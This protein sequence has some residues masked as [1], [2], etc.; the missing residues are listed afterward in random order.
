MQVCASCC[1]SG[2]RRNSM[3]VNLLS[4]GDQSRQSSK[5]SLSA[6]QIAELLTKFSLF[7][8]K[9]KISL[10]IHRVVQEFIRNSLTVEETEAALELAITLFEKY[11]NVDL[12]RSYKCHLAFSMAYKHTQELNSHLLALEASEIEMGNLDSFKSRIIRVECAL[13]VGLAQRNPACRDLLYSAF[14]SPTFKP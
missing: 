13:V 10:S 12:W 4:A 14:R 7:Q 1:I 2:T 3:P 9:T 8:R 11:A 5:V 6:H